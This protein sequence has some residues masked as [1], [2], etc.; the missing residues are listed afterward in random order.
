MYKVVSLVLLFSIL[1]LG[2]AFTQ[3]SYAA[4][5]PFELKW[6]VSG[7]A[8]PGMFLNPEHLAVDLENNIYVTDLGNSRIQKFDDQG[9]YISSWGS[10]GDGPGEFSQPSGIAVG[11]DHVFVVD[12]KL[13]TVQKFDEQGN[14]ITQWGNFGNGNGEFRSPSGI[15]VSEN[16]FIYV[17]DT[18]NN[19]I[20]E[21]TFDGE[22]ISSFGKSDKREGNL[23]SPRDIAIDTAGKFFVTDPGNKG[24]N[25]YKD[26]G[27]FLRTF[28]SSVGGFSVI[29]SGIIFDESNNFYI[30]DYK[31]NRIIQFNEHGVVLSVFGIMGNEKGQFKVPKDVAID[32]KGF[33]YVVD[34]MAH[35]I[36]KFSTPIVSEK[37]IIEQELKEQET[38]QLQVEESESL[39]ELEEISEVKIELQP[40]NPIPNDFKKPV[41]FVPEDIIIEATS[42]LTFVN[43]G[44]ADA[45]D[46][47]GILSLSNNA[48]ELFPLGITT[49]IWTSIDG[50]GNMAISPQTITVEDTTPAEIEQLPEIKFEAK[51]ETQNLIPLEI[52]LISDAVGVISLEND[53]PEVFPL[54]E[55]IVTWTAIDV[56]QNIS[57]MEQK[58]ILADSISPRV[59]IPED[60]IIE[61]VTINE[62]TVSFTEPKV[63]DHVK[64]ESLSNDA[65]EFFPIGET[66]VTWLVSD[67][68]GNVGT[69]SHKVIVLDSTPPEITVSDVTI[70]ATIPSGSDTL[71]SIPEINDIQEVYII[72]DAPDIFP[73]GNT[74]V[75]W[76]VKDQSNNESTQ[77]QNVNIVDTSKPT[78]ITP[79]DIEIESTGIETIID[80]LGEII[81]ED[82]S[83]ISSISNDAPESF[84]LGETI[85]TWTAT[86]TSGNSVSDTQLI[87]VQ[88][89]GNSPSYYNMIIG[90][91]EDDFITGT[92][93]PDLIFGYGGD[94]IIIGNNGNDCIFAGEGNDIIFGNGG[95]DNI[96][97]NQG[98]DILKGDAGGDILKGGV[99]LDMIDGGDDIDTCIV[100]EEQNSDLVVKCETN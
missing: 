47:S 14:F 17:V 45:T 1:L 5:H 36:Q 4:Q 10:Y 7:L 86:D 39:S 24:I 66:T 50:S 23:I 80:D 99:G 27:E 96:T 25:V 29:P 71:L 21:F 67:S 53:G 98:N 88:I 95:D 87:T 38:T 79:S 97:G 92:N 26:D 52:P 3:N 12:N 19:R 73:F 16:K 64:I 8:K 13:N 78:L 77:T 43:V 94:D 55:T 74:V 32:N 31:N 35:Q 18:G 70:E 54:G 22:Y 100:I 82:V 63:F 84:P 65:P 91:A 75:T 48:P 20:Q 85:V 34:S 11:H 90:T 60:I 37:L 68:S 89:C 62:N 69:S 83:E 15:T 56:M 76:T 93:L 30:T 33:L 40:V 59:D 28:D 42:G 72:N 2:V 6:G 41:I 58:I 44:Q 9:N 46:E 49:I 57:T 81:A 61:A 51:S